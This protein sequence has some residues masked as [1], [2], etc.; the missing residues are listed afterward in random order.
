VVALSFFVVAASGTV[1]RLFGI[2]ADKLAIGVVAAY[3]FENKS[4]DKSLEG[5]LELTFFVVMAP[6]DVV[7]SFGVGASGKVVKSFGI[8]ADDLVVAICVVAAD[9]FHRLFC[10]LR[11]RGEIIWNRGI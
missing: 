4:T 8:E 11:H 1:L 6:G 7:S 9:C 10:S 5:V 3:S 2:G